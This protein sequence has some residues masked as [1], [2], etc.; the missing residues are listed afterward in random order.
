MKDLR[1]FELDCLG[2]PDDDSLCFIDN[3][4]DGIEPLSYR[5]GM[6]KRFGK[7]YPKDAKI[8][9]NPENPGIKL[10]PLLGTTRNMILGSRD[11]KEAIEKH[12]KNEIEYLPFTLYDHRKRVHSRDY[13]IINPIGTFDCLDMK[14]SVIKWDDENPEEIIAIKEH[15]L[16]RKKVKD[17]PQ[18]F[19]IDRDPA[20]YVVGLELAREFKARNF[21]NIF[22]AE[23][24]LSGGK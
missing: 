16:D 11:F 20:H 24:P 4:V 17:A 9:M 5:A 21:S 14:E 1:F 2:D 6:G 23:L 7:D 3:F 22:W 18:F 8:F 13:F 19:R 10:S 15:V 12:C